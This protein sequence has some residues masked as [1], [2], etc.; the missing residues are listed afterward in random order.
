M[1]DLPTRVHLWCVERELRLAA[2]PGREPSLLSAR[3][4]NIDRLR[5]YRRARRFPRNVD[6]SPQASPIFV[7]SGNRLCA[8]ADLMSCSG[9]EASAHRI[10]ETANLARVHQ[11][12]ADMLAPWVARSGLTTDEL[13]RI[14]PVYEPESPEAPWL[15]YAVLS[16]LVLAPANLVIGIVNGIRLARGSLR[17]AGARFGVGVATITIGVGLLVQYAGHAV[18]NPSYIMV[19]ASL[20]FGVDWGTWWRPACWSSCSPGWPRG[21]PCWP[22]LCSGRTSRPARSAW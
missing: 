3:F 18:P 12:D 2:P 14:Q 17:A 8:V 19:A 5:T 1:I 10:A 16:I 7:D 15:I 9:E 22:G 4:R 6:E 13:A 11:M 21:L 20:L